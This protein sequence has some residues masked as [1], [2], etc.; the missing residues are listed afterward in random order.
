MVP[1]YG[2]NLPEKIKISLLQINQGVA[3]SLHQNEARDKPQKYIKLYK[4]KLFMWH[5]KCLTLFWRFPYKIS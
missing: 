5:L 2:A 1:I 4:N 3:S